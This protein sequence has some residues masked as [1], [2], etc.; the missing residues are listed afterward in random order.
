LKIINEQKE[1][2]IFL[3]V[4]LFIVLLF[5]FMLFGVTGV[6]VVLGIVFVLIPFYLIINNFG[7]TEGEKFVFSILLGL[8]IFPSL[9]YILGL[10]MSFRM[11]ILIAFIAF[12]VIAILLRNLLKCRKFSTSL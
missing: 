2:I 3:S 10:V 6:K 1:P 5:S 8:T 12:V 7:L 9:V 11:A 4:I